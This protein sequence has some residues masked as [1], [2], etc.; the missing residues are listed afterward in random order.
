MYFVDF[1]LVGTGGERVLLVLLRALKLVDGLELKNEERGGGVS[2]G[3][4]A[5]LL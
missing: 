3:P 5:V 4:F 1:G 2:H